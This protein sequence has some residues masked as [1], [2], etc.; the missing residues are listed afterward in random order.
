[1]QGAEL[2]AGADIPLGLGE[3][4]GRG[5]GPG[6]GFATGAE[7][8]GSEDGR[9]E[10]GAA[11]GRTGKEEDHPKSSWSISCYRFQKLRSFQ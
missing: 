3:L 6:T 5:V 11:E 10:L 8:P 1:M 2:G 9:M 4:E 7:G